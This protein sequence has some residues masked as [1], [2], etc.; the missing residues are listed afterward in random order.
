VKPF[1]LSDATTDDTP[2]IL[3]MNDAVVD[4]TS[5]MDERR[6]A[7][8]VAYGA[9]VKVARYGDT[10]TGFLITLPPGCDYDSINYQWFDARF[11][12]FLYIDRI[13]VDAAARTAGTGNQIYQHTI[14][15][16]SANHM[17]WLAA[18]MNLDPPNDI[19]IAF[20]R[21][22]GFIAVGEQRLP[23]GKAVSMQVRPLD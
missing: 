3:A 12:R 1:S 8:I 10:V 22:H 13:V 19:S 9:A 11:Q 15:A 6:L 23:S 14:A 16:A 21:K 2:A 5:P 4:L 18:E 7:D 17:H 20:H